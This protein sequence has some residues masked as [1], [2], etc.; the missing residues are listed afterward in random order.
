[1]CSSHHPAGVSRRA[2]A[3]LLAAG[4]GLAL[5]PLRA[6]AQAATETLCIMCIDH[7]FVAGANQFFESADGPRRG[8]YDVVALAGASLA[9]KHPR[10]PNRP[11]PFPATFA[12]LREQLLFAKQPPTLGAALHPGITRVVVLDHLG[13]G[14]YENEYGRMTP[15]QEVIR[16]REVADQV[17]GWLASPEIGLQS[18][19][20]LIPSV[21]ARAIPYP[22]H[23]S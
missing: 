23:M 18:S 6:S 14:A 12:A 4:A 11:F 20:W 15:A 7:K 9:G 1:M 16:H 17:R 3:G 8:H 10:A 19:F 13:C 22:Y 2:A 21:G 5:A